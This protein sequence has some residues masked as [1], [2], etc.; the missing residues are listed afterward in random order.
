M[1][2]VLKIDLIQKQTAKLLSNPLLTNKLF[3]DISQKK[4]SIS[5]IINLYPNN[6]K[7]VMSS[8]SLL[9]QLELKL[10]GDTYIIL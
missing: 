4:I 3:N 5:G 7:S 6:L 2:T 8:I 1:S 10:E 9:S